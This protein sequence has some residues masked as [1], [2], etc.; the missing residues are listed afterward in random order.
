MMKRGL[1]IF[2]VVNVVVIL[3]LGAAIVAL[4][5]K[6]GQYVGLLMLPATIVPFIMAYVGHSLSGATGSPFRGLVW[7]QTWWYFAGWLLAILGGVVIVGITLG[8]GMAGLDLGLTDYLRMSAEQITK[9]SGQTPPAATMKI[10]YYTGW[11]TVFAAPTIG[12]WFGGAVACLSSFPWLGWFSRRMLVYGRATAI[13]TLVG[14]YAV[15]SCIGGLMTNPQDPGYTALPMAF[16][17]ALMAFSGI[18]S[19]PLVMWLFL[20]TRSAVLPAL[21]TAAYQATFAGLSVLLSDRVAWLA[22][23][24]GLLAGAGALIFG[25]ALWLWKDPGGIDLAVA[26]V[27]YDGTPLT[28]EQMKALA[29]Q[30]T[31]AVADQTPPPA[32]AA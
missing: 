21:V 25:M 6:M 24:S 4:Q 1:T 31:A 15:T 28:P 9:Q 14:L 17:M 23:P 20:R 19:I 13:W 22:P 30:D 26:G 11:S 10:M 32:S 29:V 3:L 12:A 2:A 7:G 16:K 5:D 18:S 27:A 8:L